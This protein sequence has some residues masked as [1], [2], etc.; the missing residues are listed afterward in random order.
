MQSKINGKEPA[1]S[2]LRDKFAKSGSGMTV[3]ELDTLMEDF[4][5]CA[6]K[7]HHVE[8]GWPNSAYRVSKVGVSALTRI[9]HEQLSDKS[10]VI[11]HVHPGYVSQSFSTT[12]IVAIEDPFTV[13][14]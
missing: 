1:A 8:H 2:E 3:E 7:G 4:V 9:L 10:I 11:N 5:S 14:G 12:R 6:V 13:L